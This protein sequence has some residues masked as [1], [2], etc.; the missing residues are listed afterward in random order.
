MSSHSYPTRMNKDHLSDLR[1]GFD[2]FSPNAHLLHRFF[3]FLAW[4]LFTRYVSIVNLNQHQIYWRII[5]DMTFNQVLKI[6]NF[7]HWI[8]ISG[9][10]IHFRCS[11]LLW[12]SVKF[13]EEWCIIWPNSRRG[14]EMRENLYRYAQRAGARKFARANIYTNKVNFPPR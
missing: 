2:D 12:I 10:I 9:L 5:Y 1:L 3:L 11:V 13:A 6:T 14:V 4:I 8:A 7:Q